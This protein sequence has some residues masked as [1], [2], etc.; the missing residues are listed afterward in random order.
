MIVT[1][2]ADEVKEYCKANKIYKFIRPVF[3]PLLDEAYYPESPWLSITKSGWLEIANSIPEYKKALFNNQVNI[4]YLI[5]IDERYFHNVYGKT[6]WAGFDATVRINHRKTIID[7]INDSL[8]GNTNA[9]KSIQSMMFQDENN[10]QVSAVKITAIDDKLKEGVYLPEA[11][12][13]NSEILVAFGVDATL[14]GGAGIP[15]EVWEPV[16]VPTNG[17]PSQ[18][19]RL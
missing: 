5:E 11:S 17:K 6:E 16:Q 9:G 8:S 15:A 3:Y 12:A 13:A 14:I 1:G 2:S 7:A 4:K 19:F 18:F 10:A